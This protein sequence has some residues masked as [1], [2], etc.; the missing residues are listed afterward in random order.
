MYAGTHKVSGLTA[1]VDFNKLQL[2]GRV[3]ETMA[4]EP[5]VPKLE[6]FG[7]KVVECDGHDIAELITVL[8]AACEDPDA[9]V[10]V[11]AHTVKGKGVPFIEDQVAWHARVPTPE[12]LKQGLAELGVK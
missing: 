3:E 2:V 5:L 8:E 11:L 1:I 4:L 12:E 7:W 10:I 9:P 6:S